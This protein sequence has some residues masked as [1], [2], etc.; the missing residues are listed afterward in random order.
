MKKVILSI[1][2][3]AGLLMS[4]PLNA[5]K[6]HTIGDSTMQDYD[7]NTT[8]T[9]GW[10]TYLG[11]FFDSQYVTVNNRGKAGT[12]SRTFYTGAA[13]WT[14][15]KSQM[16]AGDYVIIQFAHND[17]N[18]GG[19]DALEYNA[20]L[21]A[22]SQDTLTDLRGTTPQTTYKAY[23]RKFVNETRAL[24]CNPILMGPICRF[25]FKSDTVSRAAQHDLGDK[26]DKLDNGTYLTNQ[27][28]PASDN[29]MDYVYAMREVATELEVPFIDLTTAT[30]E[31]Y[32]QYG[33]PAASNL[34]GNGEDGT[35]L[36]AMGANMI[37]R[38]AA[39]ML[40]DEGILSQY[41]SIP[42]AI[43]AN[44]SSI[45]IGEIYT[46]VAAQR[47]F[48]LTG[49][50]LEP[51][52]GSV[53]ITASG[54]ITISTDGTSFSQSQ[55]ASYE[56]NTLFQK[57]YVRALYS[58]EGEASDDVVVTSGNTI[59]TVP[60]TASVIS[61]V[62]GS[63]V[64]ATWPLTSTTDLAAQTSGPVA[65]QMSM[66]CMC[67]WSLQSGIA[68]GDETISMVRFHNADAGGNK[69]DWPAGEIDE[70]ESRYLDFAVTA[71]TTMD[72]HVTNINMILATLGTNNIGCHINAGL[73]NA[74]TG[75]TTIYERKNITN[76]TAIHVALTPVLTIPAGETM[77]IR[78]LPWHEV[79]TT[80]SGKY[81]C[82]K[83]LVIEGQAFEAETPDPSVIPFSMAEEIANKNTPE[84][85]TAV[86]LPSLPTFTAD[87]TFYIDAYG[88]S[89]SSADNTA[90][91]QAALDAVPS[92][93]GMVVIPA[94]TWLTSYLTMGS[95]TVLHLCAGAT[96]KMLSSENYLQGNQLV[97][98]APLITGK[99]GASDIVIE[100]ESQ[101][102]SIIDGQG[103]PWWDAVEAN[104]DPTRQALIRFWQG[105]RYLFRNFRIQNAPNT[106]IAI[107]KNGT[108]ANAT[109]HHVTIKNPASHDVE[110]PSHNTDGIPVWTQNV[111]IYDCDIDTGDD[112]V[113]CDSKSQYVHVWNCD[114]KA[115]HGA[116][117][118][119][120]T[121][122]LH[123]II[124]EG[125]T[126]TG[127]DCGFRLKSNRDR[128][129]DVHDIIFRNCT[130][131]G[132]ESPIVI[133]SW[134]D[135]LPT[136]GP[137]AAAA[138]PE[139]SIATTPYFHNILIK[140][141]TV[142]GHTTY[143][144]S[145]KN[146]YGIFIYGR[147]ECKVRDV[148]FDNVNLTHS[149]GLKL[150]F[151][152]GIKFQN[153]NIVVNNTNNTSKNGASTE[154]ELPSLLIEQKYEGNFSWNE[155]A[156]SEFEPAVLSWYMGE[157]GGAASGANSITGA[158]GCDAEGFT[159]AITGNTGKNWS[160]G[161]GSIVYN[162]KT[163]MT[164]KNSNGA[165]NTVTLP[166]GM[167]ASKVEFYATTN[168]DEGN[169]ILSEFNNAS[170]SDAVTGN[171]D[172][173]NPAYISKKITNPV[174]SF[175][176]TFS[177]K[178][179][180]FIMVI[181]Y[182][183][184]ATPTCEKPTISF[185][186][187]SDANNGFEVTLTN[188]EEG[189]TLSYAVEGGAYQA[190]SAPFYVDS[191]A[192]VAAKA[193]KSG[194]KDAIA[195]ATAPEHIVGGA[196][197]TFAWAV[198][199][200]S[201]AT[202]TST[203]E[204]YVRQT[205]M[206]AGTGLTTGT[207]S[208]YSANPG[209]TM[210]TYVPAT[211][212]AGAIPTVMIEYSVMM[213]K[214]TTFTLSEIT[215]DAI[216][217]GTDNAT[218]SWSYTVDGV[219]SAITTVSKDDL[220]R[221]NNT[222]GVPALNHNE[223]V[224]ATAGQN[225][226]VRFYV[227]GFGNTKTFA[228]SNIQLIGTIGGEPEVR[229]FTDF[230]IEFRD[231][232]YSVI[233]PE[234]GNLPSGVT[235]EGTSYNG[236]QHG[237]YGGSI[238]VP[239]DGPVKFTI[240]ACQYSNSPITVKKNGENLTT[241]SNIAPCG[242]QKPNYN[243]FVTWTYNVEEAATLTFELG[244]NTYVPYFFAEACEYVPQVEVRYYDVDGTTLIGS[245]IVE[246][247]SELA[248]AYGADDVTVASGKAF[249]GWFTSKDLTATKVPEGTILTEDLSI[250]AHATDIEVA[251]VGAV[252][253]YD[254]CKTYFYPEDHELLAMTNGSYHGAQHGYQFGSN[255]TIAIQ[256]AGNALVKFSLCQ[257]GNASTISCVDGENNAVDEPISLP[258][259]ADGNTGVFRYNG[260][261]TTLTF[262]LSNGGYVHSIKVYNVAQVPTENEA[263]YYVLGAG[264]GAGL[265]L[266]LETAQN[267]DVIFLPNGTYD[268]GTAT[269][270]EINASI[271]LI[272]Q[273][274]E[275][276][277][278]VN[279]P[280]SAG[281]NN[282]ETLHLRASGI[283]MQ[284]LAIRCDVSYPGSTAGG[285]GI[286]LQDRGDKNIYKF[287]NLQGN[288][289]TYL[290][291]YHPTQR[292]YFEDC[293]IE[294]TVDYICGG[295]NIWFEKTLFYNNARANADVIFAPNT[296]A[297]T[298]YGYVLNNCTID[299]DAGQANK[300]NLARGWQ[301]SPAVTFLNTTCLIAPSAK[302][303]TN[304]GAGLVVRF[305]EYNTHMENGT[306]ITGH[307]LDGLGYADNSD[308]IYLE[309][310]GDYTYANVV[311]GADNWDPATIAAQMAAEP[312]NIDADAA[313]LVEEADGSFVAIVKG[314]ALADHVGKYIRKANARGGFGERA[315]YGDAVTITAAG[316]ATYYNAD[317]A[318]TLPEGLVAQYVTAH[319]S[320]T[321][322]VATAYATG[323]VPA[324]TPV[325]LKG[326]EGDYELLPAAS[327]TPV[328]MNNLL[329][330]ERTDEGYTTSTLANVKYYRLAWDGSDAATLGFSY[331]AEDGAAFLLSETQAYLPLSWPAEA[332]A[333]LRIVEAPN[334]ETNLLNILNASEPTKFIENGQLYI[335]RGGVTYDA[336]G[337][338]VR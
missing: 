9:R 95:K 70:N 142:S 59:F 37:A 288:Q 129:G 51:A 49:Y 244:G 96:L 21:R 186:N 232:P 231:N 155:N 277:T 101:E 226:T 221:D 223:A 182:S 282:S 197:A 102:T 143:R 128:S 41:I 165:Q 264:D 130:M 202:V 193:S 97:M 39:Q 321:I 20:Y 87:N 334:G 179:V 200:E 263:G 154:E 122:D 38:Q 107:G 243:Q 140:D 266:A 328:D 166:A 204:E 256:V 104:A 28:V 86:A 316:Y 14:S 19:M 299:G 208:A 297:S 16:S 88:A 330:G 89:T 188:N 174:N 6:V 233:L 137:E 167:Y 274:M 40:K 42:T 255:G 55:T 162:G 120:Y 58:A 180:C 216:K 195:H 168:N 173:N 27:S 164:L 248:Y 68:D 185:G 3:G 261:A 251:T 310:I 74:M 337:R 132:V 242:E 24:G 152:E 296:D 269:L 17:E 108:G 32:N 90:A 69:S 283:Y 213:K 121:V 85:W 141:V 18:N 336:Y 198:G 315:Q 117:I 7:E 139:D 194:Y 227:S 320:N 272:G 212:N 160:N 273:S 259:A 246:G 314:S 275:G 250:C 265:L 2:M 106:N 64:S 252:F 228:L 25:W 317:Q 192:N 236:G 10:A 67:A 47:E 75:V 61:L 304:M 262:T 62:G 156:S 124:Y 190:Y 65:A 169:G 224:S 319:E 326:D 80:S 206:T 31:M 312:A 81:I 52:E 219:E 57:V 5:I 181:T 98:S 15:V 210:S 203:L 211:S 126:F 149:K 111:N 11:S 78:I 311:M 220:L 199:N 1:L 258:V 307:N 99:S 285:V 281:M 271:S 280:E 291:S 222:S 134:Y 145:E 112:N 110:D 71:P 100:G 73:G 144:S 293:R 286:A 292:C 247:G 13:F 44:P 325:L 34:M 335:I 29:S 268:F 123:H 218:Y 33:N 183:N 83:D 54:N 94:G 50:G 237:V 245:E 175:T 249:R 217:A 177:S 171:K 331:G 215:Y 146:Y 36:G 118:G 323:A 91:I 77:H 205:K 303:Y 45:E 333:F 300:W 278:I 105:E 270:T 332:P 138:S 66:S 60:V 284:D 131:T 56:G 103:A 151:C 76:N 119:S 294:G 22:N 153:C 72:V 163:Y 254:L 240:G 161:N 276:V 241:V 230:K 309:G 113:V 207:Y 148:T 170:C 46:G 136:G 8:P 301:K 313:Y 84:G 196:P 289:D 235:V 35:H 115:G 234:S 147:P 93:G 189:A 135:Q 257:Y 63:T 4:A 79:G 209:V 324:A 159:I 133:T 43:S 238:T 116:S 267:G 287:V 239:V 290:S 30:K 329:S 48:L 92:T 191:E 178:Q 157:N 225:V 322:T 114:F 327:A 187:W 318:I 295:G 127:T 150:N 125:I 158:S 308:A 172:Y 26:F 109:V 214:G 260:A 82:V 201:S 229:S 53:T 298:Q 253:D 302:G 12:S 184:D 279:H 305:H 338:V 306:A 176:F 23:L